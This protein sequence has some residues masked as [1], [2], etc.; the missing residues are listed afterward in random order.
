MRGFSQNELGSLVYI[1]RNYELRVLPNGTDSVFAIPDSAQDIQRAVPTG[2]N[3]LILGNLE[4]RMPSPFLPD[5]LQWTLFADAGD[6]WT[7]GRQ[8]RF[9]NFA[10]KVTP[11]VQLTAFSPVGPVR[12]VIGYNPYSRPAG[13]LYYEVPGGS[14]T[15]ELG[16]LAGSLPCLSFNPANP[17]LVHRADDGTLRQNEG[18]CPSTFRP[19]TNR[20]FTSRLTFGLAI[21]Q[22][23]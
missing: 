18:I 16:S 10:I 6:V 15:D 17:L 3:S 9:Q 12:F 22:A 23:F 11:G 20:S 19:Q 21:G 1:A 8:D 14:P 7:R 5:L 13:P 4:L 2:G